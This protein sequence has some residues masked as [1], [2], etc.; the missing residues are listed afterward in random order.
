MT[1]VLVFGKLFGTTVVSM[2]TKSYDQ[3]KFLNYVTMATTKNCIKIDFDAN[4]E[5]GNT[6]IGVC[7]IIKD[8]CGIHGN[9]ILSSA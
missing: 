4:K 2:A 1:K 6:D 9:K 5:C 7:K 3:I 8:N